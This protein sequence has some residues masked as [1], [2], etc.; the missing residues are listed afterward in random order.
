MREH[1]IC[2]AGENRGQEP[3][4]FVQAQVSDS[5]YTSVEPVEAAGSN[6][7]R[8][9]SPIHTKLFELA[10][11]DHAMLTIRQVSDVEIPVARSKPMGRSVEIGGTRVAAVKRHGTVRPIGGGSRRALRG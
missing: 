2:S 8:D 1:R 10:Q 4:L 11:G 9:R 3:S 5:K 6:P 7:S